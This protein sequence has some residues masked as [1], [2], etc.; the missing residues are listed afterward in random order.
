[1]FKH[2]SDILEGMD[3]LGS[4]MPTEINRKFSRAIGKTI[5]NLESKSMPLTEPQISAIKAS[6]R[7]LQDDIINY[8]GTV[9][10]ENKND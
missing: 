7:F 2:I 3:L 5:K 4:D 10:N 1:M 6:Y 8:L 9:S